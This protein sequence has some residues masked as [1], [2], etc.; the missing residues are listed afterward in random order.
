MTGFHLY[1]RFIPGFVYFN[2]QGAIRTV[3]VMNSREWYLFPTGRVLIRFRNYRA[4]FAYPTTVADI[5]DSWGA[6]RIE[7][8]PEARDVLHRYADNGLFIETDRGERIEMTL[9]DGRR[10]LFWEKDSQT[11]SEWAT[12]QKPIACQ[13]PAEPDR[14]LMNTGVALSTSIAPDEEPEVPP[15]DPESTPEPEANTAPSE[16]VCDPA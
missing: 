10:Y 16:A 13:G 4:G 14:R 6:Y 7:G 9:E 12:E 8:R 15:A 2:V 3:P 11:L 5:A 1:R